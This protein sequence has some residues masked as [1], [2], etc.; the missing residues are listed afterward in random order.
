MT[1]L[2]WTDA[3]RS[4]IEE[5]VDTEIENS[6]LSHKVIP[7][8]ALAATVRTVARNRLDYVNGTIDEEHE[9]L[10]EL[11]E[12]FFLTKLQT[13][14]A[15]LSNARLRA[16]RAAQQLA[17]EDDE[18]VFRTAIRDAVLRGGDGFHAPIDVQQ[19]FPDGLVAAV[20]R[21][22]AA[23]DSQGYRNGY[24]IVAGQEV[25]TQLHT[26]GPGA[27]DFPLKAVEGLLEGGPVHRSGVLPDDEALVLSLGGDEIDRAV[28][29]P[30]TLEFLRIGQGETREFR[31]YERFLTRFKQTFSVVVLRLAQADAEA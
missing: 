25:Y 24:V 16:R 18:A 9:P 27:A 1:G 31:L 14:D 10:R 8:Q 11:S 12:D 2:N 17:R 15:D 29:E 26:R 30:P 19:P 5:A 3:Q 20:A 13:E 6:R 22:V 7:E 4:Q 23:L 28:G 21:A